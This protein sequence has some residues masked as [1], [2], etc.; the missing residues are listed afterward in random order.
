LLA[1]DS[2]SLGALQNLHVQIFEW[3]H[4]GLPLAE[5]MTIARYAQIQQKSVE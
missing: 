5:R 3:H 1:I 2:A 4:H